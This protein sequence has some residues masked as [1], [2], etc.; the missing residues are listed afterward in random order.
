MTTAYYD[1]KPSVLETV[2]NGSFVYRWG[3]EEVPC[4][5]DIAEEAPA[6]TQWRCSE[7][8]VWATVT[9]EKVTEAVIAALWPSDIEAKLINDYNAATLGLLPEH[10]ADTYRAFLTQRKTLK[11][12]I[13]RDLEGLGL[14]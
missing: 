1:D 11:E 14:E 6:A 4:E 5:H 3:I 7:A 12:S 9:R 10:Y 13:A 8:V 2:G